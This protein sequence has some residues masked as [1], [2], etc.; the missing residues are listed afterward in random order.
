MFASEYEG[1]I[2]DIMVLSKGL[3]GGYLPLAITLISEQLFSAFD[4]SVAHG[5]ALAYGHS[6]TGNPL[7]CAAAKASLEV[8]ENERVLEAL[9]PKIRYLSPALAGLKELPGVSEVRRCGFIAGIEIAPPATAAAVCGEMRR[10]GL[11]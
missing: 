4:G 10:L 8:F 9:Q 6:Y 2:P 7:G 3:T 11:I 1:V 5:N